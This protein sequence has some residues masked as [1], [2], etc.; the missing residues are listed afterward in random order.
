MKLWISPK[1]E[2]DQLCLGVCPAGPILE[3]LCASSEEI[4][5]KECLQQLA[6]MGN[7]F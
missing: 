6:G 2:F 5:G 3:Q 4:T 7:L 1:I